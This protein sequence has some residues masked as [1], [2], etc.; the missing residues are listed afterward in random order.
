MFIVPATPNTYVRFKVM[1]NGNMRVV[2]DNRSETIYL[3]PVAF[4]LD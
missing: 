2:Q 1:S 4:S 3:E